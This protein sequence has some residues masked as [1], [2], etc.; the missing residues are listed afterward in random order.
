M[1]VQSI[2]NFIYDNILTQVIY[3]GEERFG[4]VQFFYRI[5]I[6]REQWQPVAL[7]SLY[8]TPD[9]NLL[10]ISSNTLLV[11]RYRGE[12]GLVLV[13]ARAIKS[14]VAMVP[15]MEKPEGDRPRHH[16][17]RFF[18]VEKPGLSLAELGTEEGLE[19]PQSS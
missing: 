8:S 18:V 19:V 4:E 1:C 12:N 15:F 17:G 6:E 7:I 14:V 9:P 16:D 10:G 5:R 2:L 13:E 3:E 11:C